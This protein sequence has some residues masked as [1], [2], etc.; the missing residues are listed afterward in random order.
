MIPR[1]EPW[2]WNIYLHR[3]PKNRP[4]MQV[5][6]PYMEHL[7]FNCLGLGHMFLVSSVFKRVHDGQDL[8]MFRLFQ[9]TIRINSL[10]CQLHI[11]MCISILLRCVYILFRS[12]QYYVFTYEFQIQFQTYILYI[13]TQKDTYLH[14]EGGVHYSS[15]YIHVV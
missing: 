10:R 1:C 9:H 13:S 12:L 3:N 15:C 6:I 7:G 8:A 4:V 5:N 14:R 2:C 11:E